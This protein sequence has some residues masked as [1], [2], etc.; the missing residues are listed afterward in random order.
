[1]TNLGDVNTIGSFRYAVTNGSTVANRTVIFRVSG[2]IRL[3]SPLTL[4]RANTTIAGQTAPGDGICIADYPVTISANNIIIRYLR[5]RMGD[6]ANVAASDYDALGGRGRNNVIID[7]CSVSWGIDE[8]LSFYENNNSTIQYC[9]ISEPLNNSYHNEGSGYQTHGYGGIWGGTLVS[10]HHNLLAHCQGRMPRFNGN[11]TGTDENADYR[12]NVLYNWG[13]YTV[14]GGEGGK[15]NVVNNYYKY[16]GN[17]PTSKRT[18]LLNPYK[19]ATLGLSY[20]K[21]Y[22]SGNYVDGSTTVTNNNW[23]GAVMNGGTANDTT[24]AKVTVPYNIV[25]ITDYTAQEAYLQVI[26]G[27]GAILPKRDTLDQR[28]IQNVVNRTGTIINVQGGYPAY[29]DYSISS[30]TAWPT[31]NSTTAPTDTD[32]DGMPNDWEKRRGLDTASA[33]DRQT[34][35]ANGYTSLENYLNG[36][37]IVAFG[38][39][40]VC[41]TTKPVFASGTNAWLDAKDSSY[42]LVIPMDTMNVVA[43]IKDNGSFGQFDVSYYVS[44]STRFD[45]NSKPYLNRNVTINPLTPASI[46]APVTVRL[47]ITAAEYLALKNA[48]NSISSIADLRIVKVAGNSCTASMTGTPVVITPTSTG[49]FG[50]Y[51]NGYFLE[52]QTS[53]F[54]T[55]FIMSAASAP[56]PL[57][58]VSFTARNQSGTVKAAWTTANSVNVSHFLVERSANNMNF[59]RKGSGCRH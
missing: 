52:F 3:T 4:N 33:L 49:V 54:S 45:A 44:S 46:T 7:H 2:T 14:N 1:M 22:L 51:Q 48:D 32:K 59:Y 28:V 21:F 9:M 27:V 25:P 37:S 11:R 35:T 57:D 16:G 47:Y 13:D 34:L 19:D 12:N 55:F 42:S 29:T 40:N 43:S 15:Y 10:F 20:G 23:S 17:T 8:T 6:K 50:T 56:V 53:S 39:P 18:L 30:L 31:L 58:L 5:F 26:K 36:D 24:L 41:I 38:T